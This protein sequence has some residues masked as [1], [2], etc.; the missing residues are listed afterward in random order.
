MCG[1]TLHGL[2]D[3]RA[4]GFCNKIVFNR[5][6]TYIDIAPFHDWIKATGASPT[7]IINGFL[8][9]ISGIVI[10]LIN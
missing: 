1:N 8:L 5:L 6:G 9:L 4:K 3:H 2:I 7:I 10:K